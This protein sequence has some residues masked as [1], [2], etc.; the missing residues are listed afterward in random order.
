MFILF[1]EQNLI[2]ILKNA[3]IADSSLFYVNSSHANSIISTK[4]LILV[5]R[6]NK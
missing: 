2:E 6:N 3:E 1:D 5:K 4:H